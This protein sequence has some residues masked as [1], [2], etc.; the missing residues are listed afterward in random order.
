MRTIKALGPCRGSVPSH[1]LLDFSHLWCNTGISVSRIK[2]CTHCLAMPFMLSPNVLF[3]LTRCPSR[4]LFL[5]CCHYR[6]LALIHFTLLDPFWAIISGL[7][8]AIILPFL[9][10]AVF[11]PGW[12]YIA[13][14]C[15]VQTCLL[16]GSLQRDKLLPPF[17]ETLSCH[18]GIFSLS[19]LCVDL[20]A[21]R[22]WYTSCQCSL[23]SPKPS[24]ISLRPKAMDHSS[25]SLYYSH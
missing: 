1:N 20:I 3:L 2:S 22:R 5:Y 15:L 24:R 14:A 17:S 12:S 23:S 13:I 8:Y 19:W 25:C 18:S 10:P 6:C 21:W 4:F 7:L 16:F 11:N 9:L